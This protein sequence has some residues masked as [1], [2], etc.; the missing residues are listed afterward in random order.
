MKNVNFPKDFP[1]ES[2][3]I[4]VLKKTLEKAW[5]AELNVRDIETWL[6]NFTGKFYSAK[7]E[8]RIAL[9]LLSNFTYY[10]EAEVKH[11]CSVLFQNFVHQLM[12]DNK[13]LTEHEAEECIHRVAFTS[14]GAASESGGFLLYF[15]RQETNLSLQRF[16]FPTAGEIAKSETIVCIDDV[17]LSGGTATTFFNTHQEELKGKKIYYLAFI[18][19]EEAIARLTKLGV[20]VIFCTKLDDR[21]KAFSENSLCFFRYPAIRDAARTIVEGY[22]RLIEHTM[23]LGY[24]DGQY[25]FGFFYNIPNNSLPIF[26]STNNW[27]PIFVRKEKYRH[28]GQVNGRYG[29]YI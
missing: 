4:S 29:F 9:W 24:K 20:R 12:I 28:D 13:L 3:M 26:W 7:E 19:G 2:A 14:I 22:G 27:T 18:V 11:L 5:K 1:S 21:N 25:C 10:N 17:I 8:Q 15:F 16:V 23:P 6:N